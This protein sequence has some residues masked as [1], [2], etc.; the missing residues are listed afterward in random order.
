VLQIQDGDWYQQR[1]AAG[2]AYAD[3][4]SY[5]AVRDG[6]KYLWVMRDLAKWRLGPFVGDW[7]ADAVEA[8]YTNIWDPAPEWA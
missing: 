7:F 5:G 2:E 3:L 6:D 1:V 8:G 4:S